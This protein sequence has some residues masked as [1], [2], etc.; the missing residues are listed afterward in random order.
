MPVFFKFELSKRKKQK[1]GKNLILFQFWGRAHKK[2][3][4][5]QKSDRLSALR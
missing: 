5:H 1:R 4:P 2:P 3:F